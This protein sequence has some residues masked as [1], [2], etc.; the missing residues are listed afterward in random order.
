MKVEQDERFREQRERFGLKWNCE[1][2]V[3][4]DPD[5]GCAHGF[6][7]HRHL[8]RNLEIHSHQILACRMDRHPFPQT[9]T[10]TML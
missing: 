4:F 9:P 1:D 8:F 2:C 7:T 5:I 3:L 6:P 10:Q